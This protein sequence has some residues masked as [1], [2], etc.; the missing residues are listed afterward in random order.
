M[1]G[2]VCPLYFENEE[3]WRNY[4]RFIKKKFSFYDMYKPRERKR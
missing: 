3:Q 4:L 1:S 2:I